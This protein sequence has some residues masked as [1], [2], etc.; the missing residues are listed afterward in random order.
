MVSVMLN[1]WLA[2][3]IRVAT[4]ANRSNLQTLTL[5]I[6]QQEEESRVWYS[7]LIDEYRCLN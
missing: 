6:S 3:A 4:P 5:L 1:G 7:D 2:S